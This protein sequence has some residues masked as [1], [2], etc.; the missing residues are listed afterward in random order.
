M[1]PLTQIGFFLALFCAITYANAV[2]V[3]SDAAITSDNGP[4]PLN[5]DAKLDNLLYN[6]VDINKSS[7]SVVSHLP[8]TQQMTRRPQNE[9]QKPKP[10]RRRPNKYRRAQP[11][12][13]TEKPT[14]TKPTKIAIL[15]PN[16]FIS[17]S[18]GPGR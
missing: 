13:R 8:T 3:A 11:D 7:E 15:M 5:N 2:P 1:N 4:T 17:Q 10:R 9:L 18:W 14:T 12:C 16:L 6:A